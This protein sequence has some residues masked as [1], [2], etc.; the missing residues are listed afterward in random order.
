LLLL[1]APRVGK[2][3]PAAGQ[4]NLHNDRWDAVQVEVRV[5]TSQDCDSNESGDVRT[6][7]RGDVWAVV[8]DDGVCWRREANPGDGSGEWTPW[9]SRAVLVDAVED[10]S[11]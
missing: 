7:Q 10:V 4:L 9:S 1:V 3:L 6:L 11:L 8:V 5:G 2:L